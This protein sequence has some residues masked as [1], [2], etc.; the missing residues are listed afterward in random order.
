MMR[1]V[2]ASRFSTRVISLARATRSPPRRRSTSRS[3]LGFGGLH[4]LAGETELVGTQ[5][6]EPRQE[7]ARTAVEPETDL[8]EDERQLGALRGEPDV[9]SKR[10]RAP[11][12]G[13]NA[14]DR[15]DDRLLRVA[16]RPD[17]RVVVGLDQVL[18]TAHFGV[19]FEVGAGRK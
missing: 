15:C 9:T 11:V 13:G 16:D 17:D 6:D 3:T 7:I 1:R 10:E 5:P 8:D 12:S 4:H 18:V 2:S 19:R 14:V